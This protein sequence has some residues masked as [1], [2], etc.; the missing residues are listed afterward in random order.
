MQI[1]E[2]CEIESQSAGFLNNNNNISSITETDAIVVA[3]LAL[4]QVFEHCVGSYLTVVHVLMVRIHRTGRLF[5]TK[6]FCLDWPVSVC[7]SGSLTFGG[8]LCKL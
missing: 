7:A 8:F 3:Q 5:V 6:A 2:L 1:P 4:L